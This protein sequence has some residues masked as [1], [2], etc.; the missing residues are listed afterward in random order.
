MQCKICG[1][2]SHPFGQAAFLGKYAVSYYQCESCRFVQ[3]EDPYWLDE[4]YQD[5]ISG[6]DIGLVSRNLNLSNVARFLIAKYFDANGTFLDYG[7]G[8]GLFV[9]LMRDAGFDFNWFDQYCENLFAQDFIGKLENHYE[10]ITAFE[11]F[12]HLVNPIETLQTLSKSAHSIFF[13]TSLLPAN[14]P[15][16][17]EWW[18]YA[19]HEGQHIAIY[20]YE[21]LVQLAQTLGYNLYSD[22]QSLHLL[23]QKTLPD[24][25]FD[26]LFA[27][28]PPAMQRESL[29]NIDANHVFMQ[30]QQVVQ[31]AIEPETAAVE[32]ESPLIVIDGVF[33]Q[34]YETG[35]ARVWQ[36]LLAE[37]AQQDFG[38]HILVLDRAN[39]APKIEGI[40]YQQ[41]PEFNYQTIDADRDLLQTVCDD[42]GA[43]IFM[44]TY[45]TT[46]RS[47][48]SV[49]MAYDMIPEMLGADLS[50]PMWVAKHTAIQQAVAAIS[51]SENTA[52]DLATVISADRHYPITAAR[53][54]VNPIFHPASPEAILQFKAKFGIQKPY[55]MLV[56][57]GL[58]YKNSQLFFQALNQLPSR[59]AFAVVCTG[60]SS[61]LL[62]EFQAWIPDVTIHAVRLSDAELATA[63]SG[64]IALAYPSKY[65]GFGLPLVEA[66]AAAC[67]I[68]TCAN[69][70]IPE[71]AGDAAIYVNDS[72]ISE[73]ADALLEVQKP[74]T[75]ARLIERGLKQVQQFNWPD[76]AS[77]IQTVLLNTAT[78][79]A[80]KAITANHLLQIN[81]QQSEET[82]ANELGH[83]LSHLL[84][85]STNL[86]ETKFFIDATTIDAET[87]D[88]IV[89][90]VAMNL[91]MDDRLTMT[92]EPNLELLSRVTNIQ[93]QM[94]KPTLKSRIQLS[95]TIAH[96]IANHDLGDI[97]I[98]NQYC[99]ANV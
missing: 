77:T 72:D 59:Q 94:L 47:T 70:S 93:W 87:A 1:S 40:T 46:P 39:T 62:K 81:W 33:F 14:N 32:L 71:V 36:S 80:T 66:M 86:T 76:M 13:S 51:I 23:T 57:A 5:A 28:M 42:V 37:W 20:T 97:P 90:F 18:Y 12:E 11:L 29:L 26:T 10:L 21:S 30:R 75:R 19:P 34:L 43:D 74:S 17:G 73:M 31:E 68:I 50:Q 38:R 25:L 27:E 79:Q 9:R 24:D 98:D 52:K 2:T 69:A 91:M 64:A 4:A 41:I 78:T 15:P 49:F 82:I 8:Y 60:P 61:A 67:P 16:P 84:S 55:F 48:P 44:S 45:Y 7:G 88:A 58:G 99:I 92:E 83:F 65:E 6:S 85:S 54:G 35:I 56:G 63:Y 95:P 3:T 89:S 96:S 53:C 22:R